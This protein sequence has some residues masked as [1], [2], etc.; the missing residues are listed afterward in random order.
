MEKYYNDYPT[1]PI[2]GSNPYHCCAHCGVSDPEINGQLEA[3]AEGCEYRVKYEKHLKRLERL[4]N[5]DE[6]L[7]NI[8]PEELEEKLIECGLNTISSSEDYGWFLK[9][10]NENE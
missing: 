2:G 1:E 5:V 10:I 8:T 9:P 4:K 7:K 6:H 3:H